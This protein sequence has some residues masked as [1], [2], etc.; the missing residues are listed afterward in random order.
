MFVF[1]K[2]DK[3]KVD[4][5]TIERDADREQGREQNK[6]TSGFVS[7]LTVEDGVVYKP[8]AEEHTRWYQ[9]LLDAGIEENGIKPVPIEK[10]TN[11]QYNNLFTVFF[12]GLLCILPY[13]TEPAITPSYNREVNSLDGEG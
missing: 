7:L 5:P 4:A 9:R 6:H 12:T 10:R 3:R 8:E 1:P 2:R 13:V 11:T